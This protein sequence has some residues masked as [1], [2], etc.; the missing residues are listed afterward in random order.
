MEL[1]QSQRNELARLIENG[2][3]TGA[4]DI[5]GTLYTFKIILKLA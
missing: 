2:Y 4:L 5:E 1:T 3:L